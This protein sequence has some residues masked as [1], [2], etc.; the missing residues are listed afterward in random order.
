[1]IHNPAH[2]DAIANATE[3]KASAESLRVAL[4]FV[5]VR[6]PAEFPAAFSDITK[7]APSGVITIGDG[8]LFSHAKMIGEFVTRQRLPGAFPERE[9]AAHGGL[10]AYGPSL[11]ANFHRAAAFVD[12]ILKG[13]KPG[14][15][16]IERPSKFDLVINLTT[17]KALGLKIPPS[18][19]VRADE[20][21][22]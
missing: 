11:R 18:I 13:A 21:I 12:K 4:H 2:P 20:V 8:M 22:H 5:G 10:I 9:Y 7:L 19:L 17:A 15:L 14:E 3:A 16:P 6:S 1:V